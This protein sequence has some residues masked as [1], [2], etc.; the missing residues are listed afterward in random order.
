MAFSYNL[1][2]SDAGTVRISKVRLLIPDN[3]SANYELEDAEIGFFLDENGDNV[4]AAAVASCRWLARK[5]AQTPTFEADGLRV[6]ASKRAEAYAKRAEEL[7][8]SLE[9]GM[10]SV[11]MAKTD[12]YA[13]ASDDSEYGSRII[14]VQ[15]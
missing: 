7:A 5:Y 10:S 14:Y 4:T 6:D 11:T 3:G 13:D 1:S 9:G 8:L 12:G 15:V 2:S